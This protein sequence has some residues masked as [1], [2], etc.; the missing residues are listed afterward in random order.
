MYQDTPGNA[1][2]V[3][4]ISFSTGYRQHVTSTSQGSKL[5]F[6]IADIYKE[7]FKGDTIN[8][9]ISAIWDGKM[10]IKKF[11]IKNR[12]VIPGIE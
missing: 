3:Q 5:R 8:D 2:T 9:T 7:V 11:N 10:L 1:S 4:P 6:Q 12:N